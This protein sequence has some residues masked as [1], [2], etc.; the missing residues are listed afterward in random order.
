MITHPERLKGV[1]PDLVK[2][3]LAAAEK[4]DFTVTCGMRTIEEQRKLVASGKSQTM[5]SRHLTGHAV[6]FC[7]V[8]NGCACWDFP[9]YKRVADVIKAEAKRLGI[10]V[11]W[12]GDWKTFKDGP[13]VELP[14]V[15]YPARMAA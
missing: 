1:H 13:H 4:I 14:E 11:S 6:D 9:D 3:I 8:R 7:V 12:G 15:D 5:R 2:V 10:P